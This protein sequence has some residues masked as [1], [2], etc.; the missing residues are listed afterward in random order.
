MSMF[1]R[2][3]LVDVNYLYLLVFLLVFICKNKLAIS[4]KGTLDR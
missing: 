4:L 2:E 1:G 3:I